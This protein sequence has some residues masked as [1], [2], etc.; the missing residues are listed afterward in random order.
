[1]DHITSILMDRAGIH[2]G[3][4]DVRFVFP[5][6]ISVHDIRLKQTNV[7]LKDLDKKEIVLPERTYFTGDCISFSIA[8]GSLLRGRSA[9]RFSGTA[10]D[11]TFSGVIR[12]AISRKP[13]P[14]EVTIHWRGISLPG[15]SDDY[16]GLAISTGISSGRADLTVDFSQRFMYQGPVHILIENTRIRIPD[17]FPE[18]ARMPVFDNVEADFTMNHSEIQ[19]HNI[20][21]ASSDTIIRVS[22][23][24]DQRFPLSGSELDLQIRIHLISD[25]QPFHEDMYL[26]VTLK[27]PV[28]NPKVYFLGKEMSSVPRMNLLDT[29]FIRG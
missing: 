6:K 5:G 12:T 13:E 4:S 19:A 3:Y 1:M 17:T 18:H 16:P 28:S 11:G 21:F 10:Y 29:D 22:G 7:S 27:G 20:M 9:L 14:L 8:F 24:I 2:L 15:L 23:T 26:P 25:M